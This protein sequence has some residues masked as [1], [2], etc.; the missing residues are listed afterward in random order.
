MISINTKTLQKPYGLYR[1]Q[2][3]IQVFTEAFERNIINTTTNLT[4]YETI[5]GPRAIKT[6]KPEIWDAI[7]ELRLNNEAIAIGLL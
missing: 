3:L 6:F 1:T 5:F 2:F 4:D 7:E